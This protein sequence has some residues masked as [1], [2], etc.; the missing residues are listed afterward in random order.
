MQQKA[1]PTVLNTLKNHKNYERTT[2]GGKG[3]V[4]A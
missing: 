4:T 3:C 2:T 1:N